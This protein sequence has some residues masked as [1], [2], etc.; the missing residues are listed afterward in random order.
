M[1]VQ[2]TCRE[3]RKRAEADGRPS[4]EIFASIMQSGTQMYFSHQWPRDAVIAFCAMMV[5]FLENQTPKE[6]QR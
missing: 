5:R 2:E 3:I 1:S 4:K 6:E